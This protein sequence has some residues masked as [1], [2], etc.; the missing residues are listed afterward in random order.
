MYASFKMLG[1]ENECSQKYSNAS[2][3]WTSVNKSIMN[4]H[5]KQLK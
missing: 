3:C 2:N 1:R 4:Q 5:T